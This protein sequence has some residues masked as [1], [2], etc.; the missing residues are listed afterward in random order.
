MIF[1]DESQIK[2]IA[3]DLDAGFICYFN[4]KTGEIESVIDTDSWD[5]MDNEIWDEI[6]EKIDEN[7]NDYWQFERMESHEAFKVMADFAESIDDPILQNNLIKIL[8]RKSP[9]ANFKAEIDESGPYR[10]KWFDFK[11]ERYIEW[12]KE[13]LEG[14]KLSI[15]EDQTDPF[16]ER[17]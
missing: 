13:Q 17:S 6:M 3:D 8:N 14:H 11:K 15:E 9:F 16:I 2:E 7:I 5:S 4:T 10:Q 1:P 12:V